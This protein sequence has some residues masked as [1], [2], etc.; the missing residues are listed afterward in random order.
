MPGP[1][2]SRSRA[3]RLNLTF[4]RMSVAIVVALFAS[5]SMGT[6]AE[7]AT[8]SRTIYV[9]GD[10]ITNQAGP[11]FRQAYHPSTQLNAAGGRNVSTLGALVDQRLAAAPA[12][13]HMVLALGTNHS[14]W[15]PVV[16]D[17]ILDRIPQKTKVVLVSTYRDPKV[18]GV[19]RADLMAEMTAH[20]LSTAARR[21]G[22]CVANWRAAVLKSARL[23]SVIYDGV[24][25]TTT[26]R[27]L[28]ART[29]EYRLHHCS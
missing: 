22:V 24:H 2:R 3:H 16:F 18:F 5:L 9:I 8:W 7:A 27:K 15:D 21:P 29:L 19:E 11:V 10:S 13:R 14:G 26:G 17:A 12:P 6:G 23:S 4:R 25:P 20:M 1:T 28:W